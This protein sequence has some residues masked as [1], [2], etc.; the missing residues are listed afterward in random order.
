MPKR[1]ANI[2]TARALSQRHAKMGNGQIRGCEAG[3]PGQSLCGSIASHCW[4]PRHLALPTKMQPTL[5]GCLAVWLPDRSSIQHQQLPSL[6][7]ASLWQLGIL[8]TL[9]HFVA[10]ALHRINLPCSVCPLTDADNDEHVVW[11]LRPRPRL[12]LRLAAWP[13]TTV[14]SIPTICCCMQ[15]SVASCIRMQ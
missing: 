4:E 11:M 6:P 9:G 2:S 14:G 5:S 1:N 3:W 10:R 7:I 15:L 12:R 13:L 8:T